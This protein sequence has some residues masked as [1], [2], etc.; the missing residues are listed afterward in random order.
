MVELL[1]QIPRL[2]STEVA[3]HIF[4]ETGTGKER[5][6]R[7]I[8]RASPRASG[9]FVALNA[10]SMPDEL[11]EAE[12]FGHARGAFTGA[13]AAREGHVQ[14]A[15]GGT[16]FLDEVADLTARGQAR[17]LRFLEEGEYR[18]LGETQLRRTK[19]RVISAAN[20]D[21]EE[22]VR[23]GTFRQDLLYRL[24]TVTL[25]LP[26]LRERGD[27]VLLLAQ[28][29]LKRAAEAYRLPVPVLSPD[30]EATLAA[31]P[32][33]GNV[34][35]LEHEMER[36][37]ALCPEGPLQ[38]EH[39][40]P[41]VRHGVPRPQTLLRLAQAEFERQYLMEALARHGGNRTRTAAAL[42]ITRQGLG[43]KLKRAGLS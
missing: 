18:R 31:F 22:R 19:V 10:S 28:T 3:V 12:M 29:F 35:Q 11:F 41:R 38:M 6:A 24:N 14:A 25:T 33:P 15:D 27:D 21:L 34:R 16:L 23:R 39:L 40:S 4:G 17:L 2:A 5:V 8:H 30:V 36:L 26:A 37:V 43:G 32:W 13:L 20:V 1:R 9:P 42:G 7:A